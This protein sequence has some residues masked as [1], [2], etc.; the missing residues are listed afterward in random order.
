[1][2]KSSF[3]LVFPMLAGLCGCR[4]GANVNAWND[5][6]PT[7]AAD[8]Q[9]E[10]FVSVGGGLIT[11]LIT[12]QMNRE[13]AERNTARRQAARAKQPLDC[14]PDAPRASEDTSVRFG[15]SSGPSAP[16]VMG[17]EESG[18]NLG[19]GQTVY[20]SDDCIGAVVNGVCYGTI[21]PGAPSLGTCYGEMTGGV[22]AGAMF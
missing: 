17:G 9:D 3:L 12:A 15:H 7:C 6:A 19:A 1:M 20:S 4:T 14:P 2:A 18:H 22:C 10:P 5:L 16:P 11:G 8:L 13:I 21:A